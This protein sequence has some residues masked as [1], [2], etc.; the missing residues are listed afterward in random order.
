M[1]NRTVGEDIDLARY[2]E[3]VGPWGLVFHHRLLAWID[4]NG[5][6]NV[7]GE[8]LKGRLFVYDSGVTPDDCRKFAGT[9]PD[10]IR[11]I[12]YHDDDGRGEYLQF[13]SF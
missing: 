13:P 5:N 7:N 9:M 2:A 6:V 10:Y 11:A 3:A 12:P 4:K 1:I 8:W